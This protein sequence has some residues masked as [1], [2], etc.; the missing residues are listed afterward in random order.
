MKKLVFTPR[1]LIKNGFTTYKSIIITV[2]VFVGFA[3]YAQDDP[4][5]DTLRK[6][7]NGPLPDTER[8]HKLIDA[9]AYYIQDYNFGRDSVDFYLRQAGQLN[10]KHSQAKY[11]DAINIYAAINYSRRNPDHSSRSIFLPLIAEFKKLNDRRNEAIAWEFLGTAISPYDTLKPTKITCYQNLM[12]FKQQA[13]DVP[14]EMY[15]LAE[16]AE[17]H[18]EQRK[19]DLAENELLQ[20]IKRGNAAGQRILMEASDMLASRYVKKSAYNKAL[21]Y[22]LETQRIMQKTGDSVLAQDYYAQLS[23]IYSVLGKDSLSEV[24]TRKA[25]SHMIVTKTLHNLIYACNHIVDLLIKQHKANEALKFILNIDAK[26]K[27][28]L[29]AENIVLEKILGDCYE[30]LKN[31]PLADKHYFEMSRLFNQSRDTVLNYWRAKE[32][33]AIGDFYL[34]RKAYSDAKAYLTTALEGYQR[35]NTNFYSQSIHASLFVADSALGD[36]QS[37]IK[38]LLISGKMKDS[39]FNAERNMQIEEMDLKYR[40]SESENHLKLVQDQAQLRQQHADATRNWLIAGS[41]MVLIIAGLLYRQSS[42]RK[43]NNL[44]V[45]HK[46]ELLQRLVTEKEWLLKEVHHRVKNNLHTV[47]CLLESQAAYLENDALKAIENSQHRIYA[48][49]LIHQKLYQSDDI[50]TIPMAEYI[51][52]L[53]KSLEDGFGTSDQI[54]FKLQINQ[55]NLDISQAIPLGLIINEAVTNS[56]KYAFSGN[57]RGEISILLTND[58]AKIKLELADNGIGMPEIGDDVESG[59]LGLQLMKGLSEDIDAD[60]SFEVDNGTRIIIVFE[61]DALDGM[62]G[63]LKAPE[64]TAAPL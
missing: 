27:P 63:S 31:R 16:I 21:Y 5:I 46:N 13:H 32:A 44:I 24:W 51:P 50:K 54:K 64:T 26:Y 17:I 20:V 29:P 43:K 4:S 14:G 8:V 34:R 22:A 41:C 59:S 6:A 19:N 48:M 47:I 9:A 15:Y 55:V 52:E 2:L 39:V 57:R 1:L 56:I 12:Q 25:L 58:G 60:I 38:H 10:K 30:G 7:L 45:T 35:N 11:Q 40:T 36:Y 61:R 53:V 62:D 18:L 3:A 33:A 28:W 23:N 42:T 49:S 37:A